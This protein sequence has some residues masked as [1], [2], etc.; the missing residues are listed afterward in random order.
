MFRSY[1][2]NYYEIECRYMK[3]VK[4]YDQETIPDTP[5]ISTSDEAFKTGKVGIFLRKYFSEPSNY[6]KDRK[7]DIRE[8]YDEDGEERY[9]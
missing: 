9:E 6:E 8:R 2:E 5:F 1:Y 7:F 4:V 3:D